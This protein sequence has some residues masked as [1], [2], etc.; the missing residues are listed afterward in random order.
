[1]IKEYKRNKKN[2]KINARSVCYLIFIGAII[3]SLF[4]NP[5]LSLVLLSI[6]II[7]L[8]I[9]NRANI[10]TL[11]GLSQYNKGN[12]S[13]ALKLLKNAHM[14][15]AG[16]MRNTYNYSYILLREGQIDDAKT[17]VKYALLRPNV[18]E[19]EV[20][21]GKEILSMIYYKQGNYEKATEVMQYVFERYV[22]SNV[23]GALGYYK[24]LS[25]SE[26]AEKFNLEAYDYNNTDKVILDNLVQLYYDKGDFETAKKYSDEALA[27]TSTGIETF[28]H[29]GLVQKALGNASE[30]IEN[31]KKALSF[32]PS[33]LTTVTVYE[34]ENQISQLE[35]QN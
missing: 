13:K 16:K 12:R 17:A 23:Y 27:L 22:N 33:F 3:V 18:S 32:Q 31:F 30:A 15:S 26:D 20:C 25:K 5:M 28:Y 29:A 14:S 1:M 10:M 7:I 35:N 6:G 34:I 8:L 4:Y 11:M 9:T 24:I 2:D 19:A 21:Q